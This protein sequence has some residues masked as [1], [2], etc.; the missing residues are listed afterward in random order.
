MEN[1]MEMINVLKRLAELDANNPNVAKVNTQVA[2]CGEVME[3]PASEPRTPATI[4]IT[5]A[6]GEELGDMLS[7]IMQLAGVHQVEPAELGNDPEPATFTAEPSFGSQGADEIRSVI[8]KLHPEDEV[9]VDSD[10]ETDEGAI[11]PFDN[12]PEDPRT[13]Q[14]FDANQFSQNTNDGDGDTEDGKPRTSF[15]PTATYESLMAEYKKFISEGEDEHDVE[16]SEGQVE[17]FTEKRFKQI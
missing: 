1:N 8:D 6:S 15:Q 13:P 3:L 7:A 14:P 5:A 11:G 16:E 10:E 12:S 17:E 2:E 4:N 9:E